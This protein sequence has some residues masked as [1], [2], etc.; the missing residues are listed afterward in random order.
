MSVTAVLVDDH[1]L[2]REG[3]KRLFELHGHPRVVGEASSAQA[4]CEVVNATRPDVLVL[5]LV[6]GEGTSGID[7]ARHVLERDRR[8]RILF[9]S[10]IKD[11][12]QIAG[13]LQT[14]A[15]GYATKD[16]SAEELFEAV[17]TVA[18]G[19]P[20]LAPS[21]DPIAIRDPQR[22]DLSTLTMRERQI[23]DLT[24]AGL[25]ARAIGDRLGISSRTVETHRVRILRKLDASSATDL[26][27]LAAKAGLLA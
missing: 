21:I 2:F 17:R 22:G 12:G 16:Q 3:L 18:A 19:T 13:A 25:T 23:F 15:L 20:Y 27:R 1:Q 5:D 6:L 26:V 8:L 9:L 10:M 4:A 11:E 24:V 7:V 14:G